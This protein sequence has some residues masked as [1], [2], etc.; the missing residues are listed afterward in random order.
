MKSADPVKKTSNGQVRC[1]VQE[2]LHDNIRPAIGR[3]HAK[4]LNESGFLNDLFK[5]FDLTPKKV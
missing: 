4:E 1:K 3:F 5:H 2:I